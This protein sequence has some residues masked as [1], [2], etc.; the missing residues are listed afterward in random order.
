[1]TLLIAISALF[2]DRLLGEPSNRWHPLV[3]FGWL[4][5]WLEKRLNNAHHHPLLN[6]CL[7]LLSLLLLVGLPI[8]LLTGLLMLLPLWASFLVQTLVLMF[9]LGLQ[10]LREHALA[11]AQP[12]TQG[13]LKQARQA[14]AMIVSRDTQ[15]LKETAMAKATCESVLENGHDAVFAS[16]FWFILLGAPAALAHRLINTLDGMWG[17]RNVR[18]EYFGK[19]AARI[20]DL[21]GYIPARLT[22]LTYAIVG[23][24]TRHALSC[25][26]RQGRRHNSPNAGLVMATGAGA[27][28]IRLGGCATYQGVRENRPY[29]GCGKLCQ[30]K[31]IQAC[32]SLID[33]SVM[34]WLLVIAVLS[35]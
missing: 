13:D 30:A 4:A 23:K 31:H 15:T 25:A 20:D 17:Y 10:S 5:H 33:K 32:L 34:A 1:M 29:F 24:N 19:S 11:I 6:F 21:L 9:C 28:G 7:G 22:A 18:F 27:L 26:W 2:L 8:A 3:G 35:L 12:L 16:L 14:L